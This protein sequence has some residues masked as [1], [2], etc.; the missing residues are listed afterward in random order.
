MGIGCGKSTI[1]ANFFSKTKQKATLL[2]LGFVCDCG[3]LSPPPSLSIFL[4]KLIVRCLHLHFPVTC[5]KLG[6]LLK[7]KTNLFHSIIRRPPSLP[8][9]IL[10][11]LL[12]QVATVSYGPSNK[13]EK[14]EKKGRKAINKQ[15]QSIRSD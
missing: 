8:S 14:E 4:S 10:I 13:I 6:V 9:P 15:N 3:P 7:F 5:Q 2:L 11:L 1:G 12:Y